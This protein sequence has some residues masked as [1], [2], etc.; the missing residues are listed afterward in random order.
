[1][2]FLSTPGSYPEHPSRVEVIETHYSWVFLTDVYAYKLK[3]PV[4][5]EGFDFR[6]V[7]ARR[8]NALAEWRLNRRLAG[9]V[10]RGVVPLNL[11]ATGRLSLG[12]CGAP[13]DWLV[14]ML[15]LPAERMFDRRLAGRKLRHGDIEPLARHLATF[16]AT[17]RRIP[18]S[19]PKVL[20]QIKG[21]LGSSL[22][23][24]PISDSL[25]C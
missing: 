6:T 20:E 19:T 14:K 22:E 10:Y 12:G 17:A 3:K 23:P 1:M 24:F 2:R 8:R 5:G 16:F 25:R 13:V 9:D 18:I 7:E 15:R 11:S 4:Q 21:E